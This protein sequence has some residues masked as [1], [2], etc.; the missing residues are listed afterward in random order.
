MENDAGG[1]ALRSGGANHSAA[2]LARPGNRLRF[3]PPHYCAAKEMTIADLQFGV[4]ADTT[5]W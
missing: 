2:V 3:A 4:K 5:P 1:D